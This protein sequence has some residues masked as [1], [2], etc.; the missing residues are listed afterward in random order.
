[1]NPVYGA[2]IRAAVL[3]GRG[4]FRSCASHPYQEWIEY[5]YFS[6]SWAARE[7]RFYARSQNSAPRSGLGTESKSRSGHCCL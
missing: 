5:R 3:W 4:L 7:R 6:R 1:M 2:A